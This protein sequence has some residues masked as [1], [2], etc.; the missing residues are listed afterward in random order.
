MKGK[1]VV[2]N[3]SPFSTVDETNEQSCF[4]LLLMHTVWPVSGESGLLRGYNTAVEAFQDAEAAGLPEY[5]LPTIQRM[6]ESQAILG[7]QGTP[8]LPQHTNFVHGGTEEE[9][10][11]AMDND[12]AD[13]D[14]DGNFGWD[15]LPDT[16]LHS[17]PPPPLVPSTGNGVISRI[18]VLSMQYYSSVISFQQKLH[19]LQYEKD[20]Q[21][22][23][24][25]EKQN[26]RLGNIIHLKDHNNRMHTLMAYVQNNL[27]SGQQKVN[28]LSI[29]L[30]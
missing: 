12:F 26:H 24:H 23:S 28:N 4:A 21:L 2:L 3:L 14:N 9:L 10:A 25:E 29:F 8:L 22:V 6:S 11:A 7:N 20:N 30:T 16:A 18:P 5:V 19:M 1:E 27:K 13:D 15:R 17:I